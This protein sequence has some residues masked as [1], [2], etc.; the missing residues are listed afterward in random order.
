MKINC[1]RRDKSWMRFLE[2]VGFFS[3]FISLIFLCIRAIRKQPKT[4]AGISL[5]I[6]FFSFILGVAL[7]GDKDKLDDNNM[8][9]AIASY[10]AEPIDRSVPDE[11]SEEETTEEI[12]GITTEELTEEITTEAEIE[13]DYVLNKNTK[14]FHYPSCCIFS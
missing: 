3:I 2:Y 7:S 12:R 10:N 14:K 6:C 5:L 1:D 4:K 9:T 8:Q 11:T 13:Y